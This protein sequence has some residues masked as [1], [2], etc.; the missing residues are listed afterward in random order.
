MIKTALFV[1]FIS[2]FTSAKD[3]AHLLPVIERQLNAS[4][5]D[6]ILL[7]LEKEQ[8]EIKINEIQAII[9]DKKKIISKRIKAL[10]LLQKLKWGDSLLSRDLNTLDRNMKVLK[11]LNQYDY[12]LFKN[13]NMALKQL[14]TAKKNLRETEILMQKNV[15]TL[16]TQQE[17]FFSLEKLRLQSLLRE[18]KDSLLIY[19]GLL[20]RPLVGFLPQ[21]FGALRDHDNQYYLINQG[22]LYSAKS[23]TP[24]RALGPGTIIFRDELTRWRETLII[25]HADNYYSVYAGI[26]N[27]KKVIGDSVEKSELLGATDKQ[28]FYFELRHFDNPINPKSWYRE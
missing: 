11:N 15:E 17:Y 3:N 18:K 9:A 12:D 25:Q 10:Y 6:Q 5:E 20:S 2:I 21:E 23:N 1:L 7:T 19:K 26:K 13:Y 14:T 4:F 28:N 24:I 16:K 27:I 22:E 8:L